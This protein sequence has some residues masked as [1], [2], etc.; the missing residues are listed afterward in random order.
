MKEFEWPA[1]VEQTFRD[2]D[3]SVIDYGSRWDDGSPPA[4]SYSVDTHPERFAPVHTVAEALL[5]YL[6]NEYE[7]EVTDDM[8]CAADLLRPHA[9]VLRAV[10]ITPAADDA[11]ALTFVFTDYPGIIVHAGLLH[12]FSYPNCGCDACDETWNSVSDDLVETVRAVVSGHYREYVRNA[13]PSPWIGFDLGGPAGTAV[14]GGG[15]A[16]FKDADRL[17]AATSMLEVLPNGRWGPWPRL[18]PLPPPSAPAAAR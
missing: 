9:G 11:A 18:T 12:D 14:R 7:V 17:T 2:A 4:D 15:G 6:R 10:R 5:A 13:D 16:G 3:G 8:S 1:A